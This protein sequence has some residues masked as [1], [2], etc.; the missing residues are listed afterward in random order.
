VS[1]KEN[2]QLQMLKI[3]LMGTFVAVLATV[4][5]WMLLNP[6]QSMLQKSSKGNALKLR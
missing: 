2:S 1:Q 3:I 5:F 4:Q 6:V